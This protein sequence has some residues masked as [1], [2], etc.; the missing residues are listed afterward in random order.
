MA[1]LTSPCV[2]E[3]DNNLEVGGKYYHFKGGVYEILHFAT[4]TQTGHTLV[5][6]K[7]LSDEKIWS[8]SIV[9]FLEFIE[10]DS[11]QGARFN[12]LLF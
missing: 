3:V 12:R 7:S 2:L 1:K 8:R 10:R 6:Y 9:D 11:Y 5:I 4:C